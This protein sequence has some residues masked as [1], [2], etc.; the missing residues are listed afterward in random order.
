VQFVDHLEATAR[1]NASRVCVGLDPEPLRLPEPVRAR[2]NAVFAFLNDIVA[3]TA[4]LVCCYKPNFAFFASLGVEGPAVLKDLVRS[5]GDRA[6]VL[7]DFKAGDIG[8]TASHYARFAYE[9]IGAGAVTV[10]PLMGADAVE[11]FLAWSGRCAFLLALTSNPGSADFQRRKTA[12]GPLYETV[13]TTSRRW[14]RSPG[15]L[16]YVVGATHPAELEALR[17]LA[18]DAPILVPG[19]GAQGGSPAAVARAAADRQGGGYLVNASRSILFASS[20]PDYA[21]AA[22]RATEDLRVSLKAQPA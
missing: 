4:D 15:D 21:E 22:R 5:I 16:G 3:A 19:V 10:N 7:L 12:D 1:R 8:N 6:P 13:V 11:P 17:G 14:S 20:G 2:P 9:V 18:P